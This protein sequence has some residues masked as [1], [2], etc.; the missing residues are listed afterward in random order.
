[1]PPYDHPLADRFRLLQ[2]LERIA[3]YW[4]ETNRVIIRSLSRLDKSRYIRVHLE[5]LRTPLE[6][7]R[8]I[9][10]IGLSYADDMSAQFERAMSS[11]PAPAQLSPDDRDQFKAFAWDMTKLLGYAEP[12][13]A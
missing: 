5:D 4:A 12:V 11:Q 6:L 13:P 3:W 1:V 9:E 2:R 8:L 7:R 10:F